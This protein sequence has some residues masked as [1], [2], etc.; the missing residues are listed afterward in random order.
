MSNMLNRLNTLYNY[1]MRLSMIP[2]IITAE[3]SCYLP[4]PKA[5]ADN[6]NRGRDN[7]GIMRKTESN[8]CFII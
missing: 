3:V 8:N 4:K 5:E 1:W 6:T 2:R 7:F